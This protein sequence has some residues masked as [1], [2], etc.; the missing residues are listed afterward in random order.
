MMSHLMSHITSS[1]ARIPLRLGAKYFCV[2]STKA[3]RFKS[4]NIRTIIGSGVEPQ[5]PKANESLGSNASAVFTVFLKNNPFFGIF[6]SKFLLKDTFL[7]YCKVCCFTPKTCAQGVYYH[8][9]PLYYAAK[10]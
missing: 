9:P 5:P 7:F 1:L 6:W 4:C 3:L 10:V 8:V 2:P